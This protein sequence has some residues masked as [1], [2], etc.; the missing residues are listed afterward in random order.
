MDVAYTLAEN[1]VNTKY[2][3]LTN[4]VVEVTKRF[5]LDS[6]GVL[7]AG[8]GAP[9]VKEVADEVKEWGGKEESSVLVYG[10]RVPAPNAAL[11]N[12]VM[13][14]SRDFDD[15][16]DVALV[17]TF[18]SVLPTALASAE[19]QGHVN[20]KDFISAIV[21]GVD[22]VCRLGLSLKL[23]RGWHYTA[24]CGGFG[25]TA[26]A[27]KILG[28]NK[29]QTLNALGIVYSM[30]AGNVQCIRD[31]AFTKRMQ[32]AFAAKAG[33]MSALFAKRGIIGAKNIMEG[34]YGF[35]N[36]YDRGPNELQSREIGGELR[37]REVGEYGLHELKDRLGKYFHIIDLSIKPYPCCRMTHPAI[38]AT[39]E[40]ISNNDI[41]PEDVKRVTIYASRSS[42]ESVGQPIAIEE[43]L[44]Q[45]KAQFSI[46]YVVAVAISKRDVFISDF[47]EDK[48][49]NS[50]VLD[51]AR[52][53]E[54]VVNPKFKGFTQKVEIETVDGRVLSKVANSIKGEPGKALSDREC[55]EK[56]R[57]CFRY[58]TTTISEKNIDKVIQLVNGL[59]AVEDVSDIATF[60]A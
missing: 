43:G 46:P 45:T 40:L 41:K 47:E 23:Y 10:G 35:F 51:L 50:G 38:D 26:A 42:F 18:A 29:E 52:R 20:G 33:L 59:E 39:V 19:K 56:F 3:N 9:G 48:I 14:H 36:L 12:S 28:L 49:R 2:D 4:K 16:H 27:S 21:V 30:I 25:A 11:V 58:S 13:L 24:I 7:V 55:I 54:V 6:L 57:T 15:T 44:M 53:V 8:S 32:P 17:H 31:N 34:Q 37:P 22:L 1:I 60:L 5:T